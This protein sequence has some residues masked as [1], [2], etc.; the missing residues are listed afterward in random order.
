MALK[1]PAERA[2]AAKILSPVVVDPENAAH[3]LRPFL[4]CETS[5]LRNDIIKLV[6]SSCK[7]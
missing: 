1:Y 7:S 6:V 4:S 2:N 3:D 5:S